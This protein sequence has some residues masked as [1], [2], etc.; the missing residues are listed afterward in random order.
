M[1]P[2]KALPDPDVVDGEIVK[3][4]KNPRPSDNEWDCGHG[5]EITHIDEWFEYD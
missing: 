2:P 1:K 4:E 5:D 3:V